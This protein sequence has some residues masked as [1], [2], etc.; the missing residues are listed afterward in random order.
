MKSPVS[1]TLYYAYSGGRAYKV[2]RD[3]DVLIARECRVTLGE[4][5]MFFFHSS[6]HEEC[7]YFAELEFRSMFHPI[8]APIIWWRKIKVK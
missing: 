4:V 1:E 2:A 3:G 6:Q 7:M 8:R 5:R